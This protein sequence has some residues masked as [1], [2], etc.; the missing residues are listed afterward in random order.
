M[1]QTHVQ[2]CAMIALI[3]RHIILQWLDVT[4]KALFIRL[5]L[6]FNFC[7]QKN[8]QT[9]SEKI[10]SANFYHLIWLHLKSVEESETLAN[11]LFQSSPKMSHES[12][13]YQSDAVM[14][15]AGKSPWKFPV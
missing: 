5:W 2:E 14:T 3:I 8:N 11:C 13:S 9:V 15:G 12:S 4:T 6:K 7:I 1:I 10:V